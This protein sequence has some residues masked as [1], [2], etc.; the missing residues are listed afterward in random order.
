MG[1]RT[2]V[3][4]NVNGDANPDARGN[5]AFNTINL[6]YLALEAKQKAKASGEN[7][8]VEFFKILEEAVNDAID[9]LL[10]RYDIVKNLKVKDIPFIGQ[11]YMGHDGLTAE[12]TIEPMVKNGTLSVGFIGIAETLKALVGKHH[13]EDKDAQT[14]GLEIVEYI[15]KQT[16]KATEKY[17]LNFSTFASPAESACYTLLKAIRKDFG[18]IE[19]VSDKEYLTNSFHLPV[20]FECDMKTKID[21]EAPYHLLCNAGAIMYVEAPSSPKNNPE[22]MLKLVQYMAQSGAVYG[23]LNYEQSFCRD[24][25]YTG[26]YGDTCPKCGSKNVRIVRIITGYLSEVQRFNP[27]KVAE[28]GERHSHAGGALN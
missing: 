6:P 17:H 24:C 7:I 5:I 21:I 2:A 23:G 25:H 26:T 9:E 12:D 20:S 15:R 19:G 3:R 1:C 13:G 11:W 10:D 22:G 16:D 8:T 28:S 14:L 27:G 4:S 18:V